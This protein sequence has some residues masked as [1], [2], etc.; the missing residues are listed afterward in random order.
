MQQRA[1]DYKGLTNR[2]GMLSLDIEPGVISVVPGGVEDH[3]ITIVYL[4]KNVDDALHA[5]AAER[6]AQIGAFS[7]PITLTLHGI[8]TFEP[9]DASDGKVPAFAKVSGSRADMLR[10]RTLRLLAEDLSASQ[11]TDY[12]P[13]VTLAFLD[14]DE[15]LPAGIPPT[16]VTFTHV[17]LH[18]GDDVTRFELAGA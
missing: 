9:S 8:D 13:H 11:F 1:S 14:P 6:A 10:L 17:S 4:G 2:S 15:P 12:T 7:G 16:Q 3:H 5:Q 18:H